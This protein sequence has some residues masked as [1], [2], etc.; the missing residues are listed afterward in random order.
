MKIII[1]SIHRFW[2][3]QTKDFGQVRVTEMIE[4]LAMKTFPQLTSEQWKEGMSGHGGTDMDSETRIAWKYA[5]TR[6]ILLYIAICSRI[7]HE[8]E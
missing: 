7:I 5:C 2:N 1:D 4:K 6:G 8:N 3:K